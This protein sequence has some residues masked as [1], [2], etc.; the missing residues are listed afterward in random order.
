MRKLRKIIHW[1]QLLWRWQILCPRL[2]Q[3]KTHR[4]RHHPWGSETNVHLQE[5]LSRRRLKHRTK[6]KVVEIYEKHSPAVLLKRKLWL[7]W[8]CSQRYR[9]FNW[10]YT[11]VRRCQLEHGPQIIE[12][13]LQFTNF[14]KHFDRKRDRL[15]VKVWNQSFPCSCH[16]QSNI[17]RPTRKR[18]GFQCDLLRFWCYS[19]IL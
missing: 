5:I 11:K 16:K 18:S 13:S 17:Q 14:K 8:N 7:L 3:Q 12:H 2:I 19:S 9:H 15:W 1:R 4:Q 10:R 6:I